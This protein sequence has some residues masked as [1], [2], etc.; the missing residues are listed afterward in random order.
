MPSN[1]VQLAVVGAAECSNEIG[2]ISFDIGCELARRGAVL[3]CGGRSGVMEQACRGARTEDGLTVGILPGSNR[4]TSAPNPHLTLTIHSGMGQARNQILVLS[5]AAIIAIAGGWGTLSEIA[6]ALKH[7]VP[8]VTVA[9]WCL[10]RPDQKPD[11]LLLAAPEPHDAAA[12]VALAIESAVTAN[13]L[14]S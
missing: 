11:P 1:S 5:A 4:L 9:G 14:P 2:R 8:V 6:L 12:I 13:R 3:L 7:R 10:E